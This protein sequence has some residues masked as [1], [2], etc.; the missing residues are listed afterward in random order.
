MRGGYLTMPV[1]CQWKNETHRCQKNA[2]GD[3]NGG[4]AIFCIRHGGGGMTGTAAG[5]KYM[6]GTRV[7][8]LPVVPS[9]DKR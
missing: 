9:A 6:T 4:E 7:R 8:Q 3:G 5:T 1:T 2:L